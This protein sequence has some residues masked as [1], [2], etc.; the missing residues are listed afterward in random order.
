[1]RESILA[2]FSCLVRISVIFPAPALMQEM[3]GLFAK[4]VL[5]A[6]GAGGRLGGARGA[7][8]RL[9]ATRIHSPCTLFLARAH[10]S[11]HRPQAE[12]SA[13][14]AQCMAWLFVLMA[15]QPGRSDCPLF[16]AREV[17]ASRRDSDFPEVMLP[18]EMSAGWGAQR[19]PTLIP[20]SPPFSREH[21]PE[22][23][24][25]HRLPRLPCGHEQ[26]GALACCGENHYQKPFRLPPACHPPPSWS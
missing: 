7:Q 15:N 5:F 14:K 16:A 10:R 1:M 6:A 23:R 2:V 8:S 12:A 18:R 19:C 13:Q 20:D 25:F 17:E 22:I 24:I 26:S 21:W 11:R 3:N 4:A 9:S